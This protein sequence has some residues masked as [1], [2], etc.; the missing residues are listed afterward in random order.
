MPDEFDFGT[1]SGLNLAE[2]MNQPVRFL[3]EQ[4]EVSPI[5]ARFI[6]YA[7]IV[8][9]AAGRGAFVGPARYWVYLAEMLAGLWCIWDMRSLVPEMRWAFSWEA[10]AVGVGI[11]V[12]WVASDP[13]FP[14]P[15]LASEAADIWNPF[16]QF[17]HGAPLAFF[18]IGLRTVGSALIVPPIE[19]VFYRSFLY[20]YFVRTD[21]TE[22]PFNHLHWLSL[23][24]T[25]GIFAAVHP[26]QWLPGLVCGLAYQWLV[27]RKNRLGDAITAQRSPTFCWASGSAGRATGNFGKP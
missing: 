21:F 15:S 20:R 14:K 5:R 7:V 6:P 16:T 22:M 13:Y 11:C 25:S 3:R 1:C 2:L 18:F 26:Q 19:E 10:V 23:V 9:L 17:G 24:V 4:L 8:A 27:L 12:V